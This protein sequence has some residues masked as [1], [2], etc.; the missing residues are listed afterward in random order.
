MTQAATVDVHPPKVEIFDVA[1]YTNI[2]PKG[3]VRAV[4]VYREE[5]WGLYMGRHSDHREFHYLE[6]WLLPGQSLR[7]TRFHDTPGHG[8]HYA[9]YLDV[10]TFTRETP[11]R[12]RSVDHYLDLLVSP[13]RAV[14][15]VDVDELFAA[16]AAGLLTL[17]EAQRAVATATATIEGLAAHGYSLDAWLA[18][19]GIT[20]TW[21]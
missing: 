1:A 6:S 21:R 4:E 14:E 15:L 13:G 11:Q 2:D 7:V 9:F 8:R 16:H 20:L 19:A 17:P 5:P 3:F 10:G 12:W 18:E